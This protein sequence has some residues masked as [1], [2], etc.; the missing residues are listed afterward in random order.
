MNA[1]VKEFLV[2][3]IFCLSCAAGG[4]VLGRDTAPVR[5]P[6]AARATPAVLGNSVTGDRHYDSARELSV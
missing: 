4:W 6:A 1:L 2:P 3:A 5:S